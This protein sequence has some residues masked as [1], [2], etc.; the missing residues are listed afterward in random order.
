MTTPTSAGVSNTDTVARLSGRQ[1][2]TIVTLWEACGDVIGLLH[3]SVAVLE[4]APQWISVEGWGQSVGESILRF[5]ERHV[6]VL[7]A[8]APHVLECTLPYPSMAFST[9]ARKNLT[10][11]LLETLAISAVVGSCHSRQADVSGLGI[12]C[13]IES[14]KLF[15][16]CIV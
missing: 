11:H 6:D 15:C 16:V 1:I 4:A 12:Y 5:L 8:L 3:V 13:Q 10:V 9:P 14:T 2:A 7:A